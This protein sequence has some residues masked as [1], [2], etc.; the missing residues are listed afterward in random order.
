MVST[1]MTLYDL[2]SK[3]IQKKWHVQVIVMTSSVRNNVQSCKPDESA[4]TVKICKDLI[5]LLDRIYIRVG[6]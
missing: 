4:T 1:W 5:N 3:N 2:N 6:T